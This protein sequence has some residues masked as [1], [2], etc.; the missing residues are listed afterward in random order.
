[1]FMLPKYVLNQLEPSSLKYM[2][3]LSEKIIWSI[4]SYSTASLNTEN[5]IYDSSYRN[6]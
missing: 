4:L 6:W 1:M 5:F 3:L 2:V